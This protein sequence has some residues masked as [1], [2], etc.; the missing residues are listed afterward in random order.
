MTKPN[1]TNDR[2]KPH[3]VR[4]DMTPEKDSTSLMQFSSSNV[5]A[6]SKHETNPDGRGT[7][8]TNWPGLFKNVHVM[9]DF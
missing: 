8:P 4:P 6:E 5:Q 7:L 1:M 2:A 9:K 3:E